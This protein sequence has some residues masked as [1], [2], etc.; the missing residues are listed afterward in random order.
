[1]RG[2]LATGR[3]ILNYPYPTGK[4]RKRFTDRWKAAQNAFDITFDG[5]LSAG[6]SSPKINLHR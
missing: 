3:P 6:R 2:H 1:M 5:R 4:G